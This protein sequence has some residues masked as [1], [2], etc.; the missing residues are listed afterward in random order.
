MQA[1]LCTA[2][3]TQFL[4]EGLKNIKRRSKGFFLLAHFIISHYLLRSMVKQGKKGK[5]NAEDKI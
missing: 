4:K 5:Y 1:S 3:Y 2:G